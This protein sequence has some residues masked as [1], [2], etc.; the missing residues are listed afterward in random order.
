MRTFYNK[1]FGRPIPIHL[2]DQVA[3]ELKT[4]IKNGY[5]E[6]ATKITED[7]FVGRALITIKKE[8]SVK[9]GLDS[10]KLNEATIPNAEHGGIIIKNITQN[11]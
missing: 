1:N 6:R 10:R 9:N 8:K 11:I 4:L 3:E 7:C 5:L 2:Q